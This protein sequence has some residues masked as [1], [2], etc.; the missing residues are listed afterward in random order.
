MVE[1]SGA[2]RD[3]PLREQD[4]EIIVPQGMADRVQVV[5]SAEPGAAEIT[6]RVSRERRAR[7]MPVVGVIV[8]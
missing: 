4:V 3:R 7:R 8:K 6:V 2:G 1:A 5:E